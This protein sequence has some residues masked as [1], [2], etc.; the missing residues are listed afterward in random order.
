MSTTTVAKFTELRSISR[1]GTR[2]TTR[3]DLNTPTPTPQRV[4]VHPHPLTDAMHRRVQRQ[5]LVLI[6]TLEHKP[7][8]PLS[9]LIGIPP[10]CWHDSTLPWDQSLHKTRGDSLEISQN[11]LYSTDLKPLEFALC[12]YWLLSRQ[13]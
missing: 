3:V 7:H 2:P 11:Q 4:G 9:Q 5:A 8:G 12:H 1:R 13:A 10:R 6:S